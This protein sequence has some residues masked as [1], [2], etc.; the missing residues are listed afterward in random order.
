MVPKGLLCLELWMKKMVPKS[1][2]YKIGAKRFQPCRLEKKKCWQSDST[3]KP[4][5]NHSPIHILYSYLSKI[6]LPTQ[7]TKKMTRYACIP[8]HI[9]VIDII[10]AKQVGL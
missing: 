2:I 10:E 1:F 7:H 6:E 3:T 8:F 9:A 5:F 4:N